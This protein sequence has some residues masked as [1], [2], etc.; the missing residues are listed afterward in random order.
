MLMPTSFGLLVGFKWKLISTGT[1][2]VSISGTSALHGST[3]PICC[4]QP[5]VAGLR[6]S[7]YLL[8]ACYLFPYS[9]ES[10]SCGDCSF[11]MQLIGGLWGK[12]RLAACGHSQSMVP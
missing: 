9:G 11:Y 5:P 2:K 4:L 12:T 1:I 10:S 6:S 7:Y 3:G 8:S